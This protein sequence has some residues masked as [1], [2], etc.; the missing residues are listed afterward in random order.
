M[1]ETAKMKECLELVKCREIGS[2]ILL[3]TQPPLTTATMIRFFCKVLIYSCRRLVVGLSIPLIRKKMVAPF[4]KLNDRG[5]TFSWTRTENSI[6]S[7]TKKLRYLT[8]LS[9]YN[10]SWIMPWHGSQMCHYPTGGHTQCVYSKAHHSAG[11]HIFGRQLHC[12]SF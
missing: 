3:A 4:S 10:S 1:C 7:T 12:C 5:A 9:V 11:N 8:L 2:S 6:R